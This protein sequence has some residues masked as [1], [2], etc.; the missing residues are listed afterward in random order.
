MDWAQ[1]GGTTYKLLYVVSAGDNQ[2]ES[3]ASSV[4]D[5]PVQDQS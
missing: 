3:T 1:V 2:A 4:G 5:Y